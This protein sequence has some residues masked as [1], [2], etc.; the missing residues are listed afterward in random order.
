MKKR[1]V[2]CALFAAVTAAAADPGLA[3]SVPEGQ[4][5]GGLLCDMGVF[6][7]K[8]TP[9]AS[10]VGSPPRAPRTEAAPPAVAQSDPAA[11]A[12]EPKRPI[13]RKRRRVARVVAARA[14]A[15]AVVAR[16]PATPAEATAVKPSAA[17]VAPT[18]ASPANAGPSILN[19][20]A[21]S[22]RSP[23]NFRPIY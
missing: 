2:I 7:H 1:F 22:Q 5:C 20:F 12:V 18:S 16:A 13:A 14:P 17:A 23:F 4:S 15:A 19:P 9:P 8:T 3:Q 11:P 6:G 21:G 10:D